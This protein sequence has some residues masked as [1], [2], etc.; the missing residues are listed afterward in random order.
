MIRK[1]SSLRVKE[2]E[3]IKHKALDFLERYF[4]IEDILEA[5]VAFKNPIPSRNRQ[6]LSLSDVENAAMMLQKKWDLGTTPV[7]NLMELLEH[8]GVRIF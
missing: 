6:V 5:R 7:A 8:K 1:K 3:K 2:Q 4:E